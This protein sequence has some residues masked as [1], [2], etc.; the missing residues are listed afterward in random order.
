[1]ASALSGLAS[2][3]GAQ[4]MN[5]GDF[6]TPF[7]LMAGCMLA[8]NLLFWRLFAGQEED[9]APVPALGRMDRVDVAMVGD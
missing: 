8:A 2:Y 7:F 5:A 4:L 3:I 1:V 6:R 9:L